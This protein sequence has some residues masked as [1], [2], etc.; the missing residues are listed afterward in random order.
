MKKYANFCKA[1]KNL[2]ELERF[3]GE[4]NTINLTGM[5][6]LYGICFEQSWKAMKEILERQGFLTENLGSPR[7]VLKRAYTAGM[8]ADEQLWLDAL[9]S[10]NNVAHSYNEA[11]A[12]NIILDAKE[13]YLPMFDALQKE[14]ESKWL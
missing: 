10:R 9:A 1:L 3:T 7:M 11:V 5:A 12:K 6:S 4:Y 2:H 13:K 14:I 8:I